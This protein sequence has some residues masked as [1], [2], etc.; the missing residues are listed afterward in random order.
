MAFPTPSF[1]LFFLIVWLI[2]AYAPLGVKGRAIWLGLSGIY[3]LSSA[4]LLPVYL[5]TAFTGLCLGF[6]HFA[7][8]HEIKKVHWISC[9]VLLLSPLVWL[10]YSL[11]FAQSLNLLEVLPDGMVWHKTAPAGLS[12]FTFASCVWIMNVVSQQTPEAPWWAKASSSF[13]FP[14][15]L[16]GPICRPQEIWPQW[17]N[18]QARESVDFGLCAMQFGL[19]FFLKLVCASRLAEIAD[20]VFSN[21]STYSSA[22]LLLAAHAYSGQ[23]YADF[24]GYTL[25]ALGCAS[26]F[27]IRLPHNFNAPY[28]ALGHGDF[29]RRWHM[30]LSSLWRD[31]IYIPLGGNRKGLARQCFNF[32]VVMLLCG[33]WHGAGFSFLVWGALHG[34]G[35]SIERLWKHYS[36]WS[37]FKPMAWFLCFEFITLSWIPFR[38]DNLEV[39]SLFVSGLFQNMNVQALLPLS[40]LTLVFILLL[41]LFAEQQYRDAIILKAKQL[42]SDYPIIFWALLTLGLVL[43]IELSPEGLP[44]FIYFSF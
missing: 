28:F 4:G 41:T 10:K 27:G 17:Q 39:A 25:M 44:S 42:W 16:S 31:F 9:I 1:A 36:P 24:A 35:L 32:F 11:F 34:I 33:L 5:L 13:F 20:P 37:L 30:T 3:F 2:W 38:A 23:I 8:H 12:F 6:D 19:G 26:A 43:S 15:L 29:W 22:D 14:P 18:P 21:P 40:G 7:K